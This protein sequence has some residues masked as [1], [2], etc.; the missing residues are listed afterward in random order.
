MKS[1]DA[2][3]ALQ[4]SETIQDAVLG[5]TGS[6][7]SSGLFH[8]LPTGRCPLPALLELLLSVLVITLWICSPCNCHRRTWERCFSLSSSPSIPAF[9]WRRS[10]S[11]ASY[12]PMS[13]R[14]S[15]A[16]KWDNAHL[17]LLL[18]LKSGLGVLSLFL[19]FFDGLEPF[20]EGFVLALC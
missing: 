7:R 20:H 9:R 15:L 2:A 10:R 6:L 13:Y 4:L 17:G 12:P 19:G 18:V 1:A 14:I 11:S 5:V 3:S 16:W 8:F